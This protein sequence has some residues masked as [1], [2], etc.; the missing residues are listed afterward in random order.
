MPQRT[1][2]VERSTK[3]TQIQIELDLDGSGR[4]ESATGIGFLDHMLGGFAKHGLFDLRAF[5]KGDLDVD[6]HHSI[7]DMGLT[8]GE[9]IRAAAGDKAGIR[10]YGHFTLP[11]DEALVL[12][13]VDLCGRPCYQSNVQYTVEKLGELDTEM[14]GEFFTAVANAAGLNLHLRLLSGTNNHHIAE[15]CF[16]A[17][18]KALDM[19]TGFEPRLEGV[20]STKGAL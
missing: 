1:A 20:W 3:E 13:A 16:K 18:G 15:A 10:R 2:T 7:E 12:C 4:C 19:A 17:F 14:I 6:S 5:C 9:A 11:M 8:L